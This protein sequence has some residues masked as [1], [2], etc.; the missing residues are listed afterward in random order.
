MTAYRR[1]YAWQRYTDDPVALE[2]LSAGQ[3]PECGRPVDEHGG[4][5]GPYG[6]TL[7]DTG[8]AGRIY[9]YNLDKGAPS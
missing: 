5:G 7:T 4:A 9:Q 1:N 2:R 3:C 8:V 6:C